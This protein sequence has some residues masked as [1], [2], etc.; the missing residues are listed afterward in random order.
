MYRTQGPIAI[1]MTE[2]VHIPVGPSKEA[3]PDKVFHESFAAIRD[4]LARL[5][6]LA[7]TYLVS[8]AQSG[9]EIID[10]LC[11]QVG[12][13]IRPALFLLSCRLVQYKG[14]HLFPMAAVGE[15][16]HNASL[17]HDDII[18]DSTL[19]RNRPTPHTLWGT[20]SAVLVGD[21]IYSTASEL[22]ARTGIMEI[23]ASYAKAIRQMSD[24]ELMQ[25]DQLYDLD[26]DLIT[27][28][29]IVNYKTA[30]LLGTVCKTAG[31][32]AYC[33]DEQVEALYQYGCCIGMSFQI[34]D[35]ALDYLSTAE[36]MG[37][38]TRADFKN[39]K[40]TYPIIILRESCSSEEWKLVKDLNESSKLSD[41]HQ[42]DLLNLV[43]KYDLVSKTLEFARG[44]TE[45]AKASL[46]AFPASEERRSLEKI[47][48]E[49]LLRTV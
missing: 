42:L 43:E 11:S 21:L 16:V 28:L 9:K 38:A 25:L 23:V 7:P 19:R 4:D 1:T 47:A 39:G 24:G 10:Y 15:F 2:E 29:K 34:I 3:K 5:E 44:F 32:L 35:D 22:M 31:L 49:L 18:D 13:Q 17:L 26:T 14:Q 30:V 37:K 48:H 33:S 36:D 6:T 45:Q 20:E 41:Q 46:L 8:D 12:K 40:I 27:Y